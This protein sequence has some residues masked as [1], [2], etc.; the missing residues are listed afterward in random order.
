M[1]QKLER[2]K[3]MLLWAD[4]KDKYL[5]SDRYLLQTKA[6]FS[7]K[8]VLRRLNDVWISQIHNYFNKW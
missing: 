2:S 7:R 8:E 6:R 1:D 4:N 5:E 3:D